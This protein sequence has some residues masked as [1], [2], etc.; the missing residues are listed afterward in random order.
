MR[1]QHGFTLI[2]LLVVIAIIAILA[3]I[4]FPVFAQARDKARAAACLSNA[5]QIGHAWMMYA[6]DY[7]ETLVPFVRKQDNMEPGHWFMNEGGYAGFRHTGYFWC[8][9]DG[10][11]P[12]VKNDGVYQCPSRAW[13]DAN[14]P[15]HT[16]GMNTR[17][18]DRSGTPTRYLDEGMPMAAIN[19][20]VL[21]VAFGDTAYNDAGP[22]KP[23][24]NW[25]YSIQA[26]VWYPPRAKYLGIPDIPGPHQRGYNVGYHDGHVK[27]VS[28]D[29][30]LMQMTESDLGFPHMVAFSDP[31]Q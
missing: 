10:L 19:K 25:T 23:S 22:G 7:D 11:L 14:R 24:L 21:K 20:P 30:P 31:A 29:A 27:W 3:A 16:I 8:W 15:A 13:L 26:A 1:R 18:Y 2:E 28:F 4:L 9:M 12:Y 17:V 6:Q 5:K